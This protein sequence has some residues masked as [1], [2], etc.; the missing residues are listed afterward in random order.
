MNTD[1]NIKDNKFMLSLCLAITIIIVFVSTVTAVGLVS[2]TIL[3]FILAGSVILGYLMIVFMS[4][5]LKLLS[6][7]LIMV[8]L[9]IV[10]LNRSF[11]MISL[12]IIVM[13]I[14]IF[15]F[16]PKI[17]Y[18]KILISFFYM[19][20]ILFIIVALLY[21]FI[22]FN[23]HDV[24]MWRIDK[25]IYRKSLGFVQPNMASILWMG[26]FFSFLGILN[27]KYNRIK[28]LFFTGISLYIFTYTQS[29]TSMFVLLFISTLMFVFGKQVNNIAPKK[30]K[31]LIFLSP[32]L[33]SAFS[34]FVLFLPINPLVDDILS[35]RIA[36]YKQFFSDY[37]IGLLGHSAL[38]NAM[39]DNGYLQS[40]LSKGILFF[41]EQMFIL[42]FIFGN[43]KYYTYKSLILFLG[44]CLIGFTETALQH[45][46]LLLPI[47]LIV[48]MGNQMSTQGE[49]KR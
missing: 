35:G 48:L 24:T 27:K 32:I 10:I 38:E 4:G 16:R 40:L 39:F 2:S 12:T 6:L 41:V 18:R 29:R 30:L 47:V 8:N 26:I 3:N 25:I 19:S 17:N 20:L 44:Y 46:E 21:H 36:L 1:K 45:F 33:L 28:I 37:G 22:N 15:E 43:K 34:L 9:L 49:Q 7:I 5:K 14:D 23:N 13:L 11:E 31:I 42:T